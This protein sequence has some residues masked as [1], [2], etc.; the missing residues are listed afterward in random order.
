VHLIFADRAADIC[1]LFNKTDFI[2]EQCQSV[3]HALENVVKMSVCLRSFFYQV[4][5]KFGFKSQIIMIYINS[6]K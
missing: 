6:K 5:P 3:K 1:T 2:L 4:T